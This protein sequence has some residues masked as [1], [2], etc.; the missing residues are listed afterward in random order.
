MEDLNDIKIRL[1]AKKN[2]ILKIAEYG[3]GGPKMNN[4]KLFNTHLASLA[5]S[6]ANSNLYSKEVILNN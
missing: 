2:E 5:S 1:E 3:F 4:T 6:S